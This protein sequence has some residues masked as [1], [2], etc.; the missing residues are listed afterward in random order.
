MLALKKSLSPTSPLLASLHHSQQT[1]GLLVN[2]PKRF[3]EMQR[4]HI[5]DSGGFRNS[6]SGIQCTMFGGTSPLGSTFGG[7]LTRMGS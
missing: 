5:N 3:Y 1:Q 7:M 2:V 6:Y 4:L